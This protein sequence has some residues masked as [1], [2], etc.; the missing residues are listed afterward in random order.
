MIRTPPGQL[1]PRWK[2]QKILRRFIA[3]AIVVFLT[4]GFWWGYLGQALSLKPTIHKENIAAALAESQVSHRL[5]D[6]LVLDLDG[7]TEKVQVEYSFDENLQTKMQALFDSYKPDYGSFVAVDATT[8][9]ILSLI[10]YN[11]NDPW[12]KDHLALRATFPSASVFKVVTAAAAIAEKKL[13]ADSMISYNG[14]AHTLYKNH[15]FKDN[16]NRW[17]N[18][19]TLK[20]AFAHSV[21][22]VFGKMGVFIVGPTELRTYADRFGFNRKIVADLPIQQGNAHITEDPWE[23]AEAASGYTRENTMSPLQGA[24]IAAAIANDGKMMEPYIVSNL[25]NEEGVTVYQ[26]T[27]T[28]STV[29]IDPSSASEMKELMRE[30]IT[31]GT[32]R[33]AFRGFKKSSFAFIDVGGKTGSLTGTDPAGKYDWFVGYASTGEHKIAL[34]ALTISKEFWKVKSSFLARRAVEAYFKEKYGLRTIA[35][36]SVASRSKKS[37]VASRKY[38]SKIRRNR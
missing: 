24:L 16:V 27:P 18:H 15:V 38:K 33:G 34:A 3:I 32:S 1:H 28:L 12:I 17:T 4:K 8:G 37:G 10:S 26:P 23:I 20:D 7:R 35:E 14:R 13:S 25:K 31:G 21:N 6:Q 22:T 29:V 30:T 5:P 2:K 11:P 9:R 19:T 36:R